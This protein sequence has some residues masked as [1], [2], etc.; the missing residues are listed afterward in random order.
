MEHPIF[1]DEHKAMRKTIRSFVEKELAPFAEKWEQEEDF[2]SEIFKRMGELGFL[3]LHYPEEY[4][5][6]GGDYLCGVILAEEMQRC[7]N[8]GVALA[9]GVQTD[10]VA[11]LLFKVGNEEQKQTYL[12][13]ALKG[14]KIGALGISEPDAGSD[15]ASIRTSAEKDGDHFI[16]NGTKTF[17]TN[18]ERC[19][20]VCLV[21]R[22]KGTKGTQGVTLFIVDRDTPGFSVSRKLD[23]V[24]MRSSDTAELIFEDCRVSAK[25]MLGEEGK[26]FYHIMWELQLERLFGAVSTLEGA[27]LCM[28]D[29]LKYVKQRE[30]FGR[31]LSKF[32][33]ICHRLAN[34]ATELEA[35]R[36]LSYYTADLINKGEYPVKEISM[37]KLYASQ[38]ACRVIDECLQFYGGYGYMMEYSVQRHWRDSRLA[39]IGAGTDEI[40]REIISRQMGL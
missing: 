23:K 24:G 10:M 6:E 40:M 36:Q 8:G 30:Q 26:G 25:N 11:P 39:R 16:I 19:D 4:G 27:R 3:G 7:N 34:M 29:T 18:G 33:A 28:E 1:N 38:V 22:M 35:S 32:Q 15:V 17:I 21:A 20:F 9:I 14:E 13:A 12:R 5:G 2:P 37:A 31:P